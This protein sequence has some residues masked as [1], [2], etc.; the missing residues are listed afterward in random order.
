MGK[1]QSLGVNRYVEVETDHG[2]TA[3]HT[4]DEKEV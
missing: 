1:I 2:G 4:D 3:G